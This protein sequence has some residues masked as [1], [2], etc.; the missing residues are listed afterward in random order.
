VAGAGREQQSWLYLPADPYLRGLASTI[1]DELR[2]GR[3]EDPFG[4]EGFEDQDELE[5][6]EPRPDVDEDRPAFVPLS[7]DVAPQMNLFGEPEAAPRPA[8]AAVAEPVD[9][10]EP[11]TP[12]YARRAGK[13]AERHRLVG[14]LRRLTG[15]TFQQI[16]ARLNAKTGVIKVED[17]TVEQLDK[18]ISLLL[19]ELTAASRRSSAARR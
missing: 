10:D 5:P 15:E 1:E 18:S 12:L 13:R 3:R 4:E 14:S 9:V 17:A 7:A 6:R 19:D 2:H 11:G 16:N 8:L